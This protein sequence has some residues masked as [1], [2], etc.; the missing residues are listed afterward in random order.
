MG[1]L[2]LK[3]AGDSNLKRTTLELGG[4]SPAI[5]LD[6]V[7]GEFI[8]CSFV[9]SCQPG[10]PLIFV[11]LFDFC[12]HDEFSLPENDF[13]LLYCAVHGVVVCDQYGQFWWMVMQY[14]LWLLTSAADQCTYNQYSLF[15][16][17]S[18]HVQGQWSFVVLCA[19]ISSTAK[20]AMHDHCGSVFVFALCTCT[21]WV[22]GLF[23]LLHCLSGTASLAKL[24]HQT[25]S[26]LSKH[27]WN[28][29]SSG[30]PV[31]SVYVCMCA[32]TSLFWLCFG[33]LLCNGLRDGDSSVVRAPDSWLKGR[34]FE[35]L[36]EQRENFLLQGQLSVLTLISVSVPPPCYCSSM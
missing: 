23:L 30:Y 17:C 27:L 1:Q 22:R 14:C 36:Q 25:H 6:D 28:L 12:F 7:D 4:K 33:S 13:P 34:G 2:I 35:S 24:N 31:D 26:C 15:S 9:R 16:W 32:P 29:C 18:L 3:A 10:L 5:F 11:L 20:L 19:V 21:D 8:I